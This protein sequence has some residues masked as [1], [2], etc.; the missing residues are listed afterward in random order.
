M[1][2]MWTMRI[3]LVYIYPS[4]KYNKNGH[5]QGNVRTFLVLKTKTCFTKITISLCGI[6]KIK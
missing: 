2:M 4:V 5:S 6:T 1:R 3:S